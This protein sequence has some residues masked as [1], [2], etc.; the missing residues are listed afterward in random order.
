MCN[1]ARARRNVGFSDRLQ[2]VY[3]LG[4]FF[5]DLHHFAKAAFADDFEKFEGFDG[6]RFVLLLEMVSQTD[7]WMGRE[8]YSTRLEGDLEME[9][10]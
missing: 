1:F 2:G 9:L 10:S 4:I 5:A 8:T 7:D 6:K 3:S